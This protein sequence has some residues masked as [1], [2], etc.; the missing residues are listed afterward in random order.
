MFYLHASFKNM[1]FLSVSLEFWIYFSVFIFLMLFLDLFVINRKDHII[2]LKESLIWVSVWI[3]LALGFAFITLRWLGK[4]TALQFLT[5]YVVELALSVDNIFVFVLLFSYFN[6]PKEYQHRVLFW[7]VMGALF[8]RLLF[9]FAGAAL[10][11]TF[12]WMI[13]FFGGILLVSGLKMLK[14][15]SDQKIDPEKN[16]VIRFLRRTMPVSDKYHGKKFFII[17]NKK[18]TATLLFVVLVMVEVTDLIFAVDSVPAV[19]A[20]TTDRFIVFTSNAFAILGLRSLYFA[21]AGVMDLFRFLHYGLS[22]ILVFIGLKMMVSGYYKIPV[23]WSLGVVLGVLV[24]SIVLS[25]IFPKKKLNPEPKS[26]IK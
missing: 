13:Y 12:H 1:T 6:V 10:L 3:S 17:E 23:E 11:E 22:V 20:I 15:D 21:L 2:S 8:M 5:G 4:D 14:Q 16:I 9:I 7:G 24:I 18:R 26:T 25:L 19:L